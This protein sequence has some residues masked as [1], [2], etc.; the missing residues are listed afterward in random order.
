[1]KKG[2]CWS[3][4][5]QERRDGKLL[6][7]VDNIDSAHLEKLQG[8]CSDITIFAVLS[9]CVAID[10]LRIIFATVKMKKKV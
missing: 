4:E 9:D 5:M 1:M 2:W 3:E 10:F 7:F 8:F 6:I